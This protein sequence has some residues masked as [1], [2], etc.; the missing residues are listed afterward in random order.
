MNAPT[1]ERQNPNSHGSLPGLKCAAVSLPEILV[2]RPKRPWP[3]TPYG[4]GGRGVSGT[5]A[6]FEAR[7]T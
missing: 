4:L 6:V 1:R 2:A 5:V 7:S 3:F